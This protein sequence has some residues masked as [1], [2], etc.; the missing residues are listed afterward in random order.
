L[1]NGEFKNKGEI[2]MKSVKM[3]LALMGMA[4]CAV[5]FVSRSEAAT[6][7]V[8]EIHVSINATKS[9]SAATTYYNFGALSLNV[10][11]VSASA[12]V[13]TNDSGAYVETY[14]LQGANATSDTGGTNWTLGAST[15]TNQYALGAQFSGSR[16]ADTNTA[17]SSD[18]LNTSAVACSTT[19]FGDGSA[20]DEGA[21]VSPVAGS[22]DRNLWFRIHTPDISTGTESRT[23]QVTIAVQ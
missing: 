2:K 13:I 6:S 17:F 7:Q 18:Y 22:R 9:L 15:T 23:A 11:S 8:L 14:T 21:T 3:K 5:L 20:G 10:S 1:R 12:L 4:L 19:Q 16:P